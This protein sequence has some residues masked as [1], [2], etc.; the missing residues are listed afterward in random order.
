MNS[1]WSSIHL[2][3]KVNIEWVQLNGWTIIHAFIKREG[4]IETKF[5]VK[6][7]GDFVVDTF[8]FDNNDGMQPCRAFIQPH[9]VSGDC[10]NNG[11][12]LAIIIRSLAWR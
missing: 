11:R 1:E 9:G 6:D 8:Y 4:F 7:N 12:A 3:K 5:E 2:I 10:S